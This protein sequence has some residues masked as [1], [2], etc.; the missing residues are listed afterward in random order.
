MNLTLIVQN[1]PDQRRK[2]WI[3][4]GKKCLVG[5]TQRADVVFPTDQSMSSVHFEIVNSQASCQLRDQDST[6]G[7]FINGKRI[8]VAELA[9]GDH[10][11]AGSTEFVVQLDRRETPQIDRPIASVPPVARDLPIRAHTDSVPKSDVI[12]PAP[13]KTPELVAKPVETHKTTPAEHSV[14]VESDPVTDGP[15]LMEIDAPMTVVNETGFTVGVLPW[16]NTRGE[17]RLSVIVKATYTLDT[18]P[19]PAEKQLPLLLADEPFDKKDPSL[20]QMEADTVPFKPRAD[21]VVVGH[22]HAPRQQ[23]VTQLNATLRVGSVRKTIRV[24]GDR[25][26]SFPTVAQM[27]PRMSS[28]KPFKKMDLTYARAFGGFDEHAARFCDQ[29]LAGVGF[30]GELTVKSIH[31]KPLPNFEDPNNLIAD[32]ESRPTPQGFGFYGRGWMPR[33]KYAGT[34]DENYVE[35]RAPLPP[36]DASHEFNNGAH[37]DLQVPGFLRGNEEVELSNLRA[38]GNLRFRL[39]APRLKVRITRF[40]RDSQDASVLREIEEDPASPVLDTLVFLP[41]SDVF[42]FVYRCVFA[43]DDLDAPDIARIQISSKDEA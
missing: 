8:Q 17:G 5:R 35:N 23:S 7:T 6:N 28:P 30:A 16:E 21:I 9:N 18:D 43:L 4:T 24:Y 22:A 19:Q 20:V 14:G 2:V 29:N 38:D 32:W 25:V 37:P 33:L 40:R 27:V 3:R 41:D 34:F 13:M 42:Y 1:G 31:N 36:E 10:V 39:P 15:P 12:A 26:W 11:L